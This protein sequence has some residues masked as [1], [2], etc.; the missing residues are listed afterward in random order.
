MCKLLYGIEVKDKKVWAEE[1]NIGS[2]DRNGVKKRKYPKRMS[3]SQLDKVIKSQT[4]KIYKTEAEQCTTC[5]GHKKIRKIKVTGEPFKNDTV[6]PNCNGN[7]F[8]YLRTTKLAGLRLRPIS[9]Q[10]A[11]AAG[12]AADK[13]VIE[14]YLSRESLD[15]DVKA[16]LRALQR[17]SAITNYLSTF[18][19][20]IS[21]NVKEDWLLHCNLNQTVTATARLSSSNPNLQNQPRDNTFPIRKAFA[22][23]FKNGK[24][25]DADWS[26]L[27]FR[28][29]VAIS[30]DKQGLSDIA[31][32]A[33]VHQFTADTITK[34]GQPTTRQEAKPHTFKPL[35]A[36][37]SGTDAEIAY[38]QEF[39]KKYSDIHLWQEKLVQNAL[40]EGQIKSPSSRIYAFNNVYRMLNGNVKGKTQIYN[41]CIQGFASDLMQT[42]LIELNK[43]LKGLKSLLILTVH[44]SLL[45][46]VHPEE[47]V[48]VINI[49]KEVMGDVKKYLNERFNFNT[50]VEF[51]F[52]IKIG[53]NWGQLV[54]I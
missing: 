9:S 23:R 6:C 39:N 43:K 30:G 42:V 22:S 11:T 27:E 28:T 12:F 18:V 35:F 25:L 24:I 46:D 49:V 52:E 31:N 17:Q 26:G 34:K 19:E 48:L 7:G 37:M 10:Y 3:T 13:K 50:P 40:E 1:F 5:N 45:I 16:F 53:K 14:Q 2:A 44:D 29:A 33:D 54:K 51:D 41:Y 21:N 36:G 47:E 8:I 38:Y 4:D 20:G 32:K 15:D